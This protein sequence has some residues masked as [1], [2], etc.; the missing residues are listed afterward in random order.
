MAILQ[1]E[2]NGAWHSVTC[3]D[4]SDFEQVKRAYLMA[5]DPLFKWKEF[6]RAL[7]DSPVYP[8][9]VALA[10]TS[11][12]LALADSK[13]TSALDM[14][15]TGVERPE[16]EA[17]QSAVALYFSSLPNSSEGDTIRQSFLELAASHFISI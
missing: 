8:L 17:F 14:C 4:D 2:H 3:P 1:F 6:R 16:L 12:P 13:L 9:S 15:C 10:S 7:L 5:I 11:P